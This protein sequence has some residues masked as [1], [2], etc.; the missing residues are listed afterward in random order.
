MAFRGTLVSVTVQMMS[1][2]N[3]RHL[4]G[5]LLKLRQV[6]LTHSY[7]CTEVKMGYFLTTELRVPHQ[8]NNCSCKCDLIM[9]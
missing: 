6:N 8:R 5:R 7:T 1:K 2:T 4:L 3:M 9:K